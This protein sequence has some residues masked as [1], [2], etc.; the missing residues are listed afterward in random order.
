MKGAADLVLRVDQE[1]IPAFIEN[2]P[3]AAYNAKRILDSSDKFFRVL[4]TARVSYWMPDHPNLLQE[5]IWN[6]HDMHPI[7][8]RLRHFLGF[9]ERELEGPLHTL[10][11]TFARYDPT[12]DIR[13][14]PSAN[15]LH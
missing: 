8:P 13:Y 4:A 5:Y 3:V 2:G 11:F 10:E 12:K 6:D 14:I 9:W 1:Q 7:F 15:I